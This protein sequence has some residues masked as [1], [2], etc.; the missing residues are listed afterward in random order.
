MRQAPSR[1]SLVVL[2]IVALISF[3]TVAGAISP[4]PPERAAS[5]GSQRGQSS[6]AATEAP[7][8]AGEDELAPVRAI[9]EDL[10]RRLALPMET[11]DLGLIMEGADFSGTSPSAIRW[12]SDA[13]RLW[14]QWRRWNEEET[15]TF[16]YSIA[17][18]ELRQL[19]EEE[20]ELVPTAGAGLV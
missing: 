3:P 13:S 16:E 2:M 8:V 18:G 7:V 19:S 10:R 5:T 9:R 15:S 11:V 17:P 20:A 4:E 14:F 1:E 6:G 12:D